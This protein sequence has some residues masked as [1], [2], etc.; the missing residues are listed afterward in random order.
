M[1]SIL[2]TVGY[3]SG[4]L[5]GTAVLSAPDT[6]LGW[7]RLPCTSVSGCAFS[8]GLG[9]I[10]A[11]SKGANFGVIGESTG[12]ELL[13]EEVFC[14]CGAAV[15]ADFSAVFFLLLIGALSWVPAFFAEVSAVV[16]LALTGSLDCQVEVVP[17]G[18]EVE[19]DGC[20]VAL[21]VFCG[22]AV[23]PAPVEPACGDGL[24]FLAALSPVLAA[25]PL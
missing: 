13:A 23:E 2:P 7:V 18:C 22:C 4:A 17:S 19:L 9:G 21:P 10:A 5:S 6:V 1:L 11:G 16:F 15:F 20:D 25:C 24:A 3:D 8:F 12:A 14:A